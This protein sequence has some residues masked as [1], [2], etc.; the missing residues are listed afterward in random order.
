MNNNS[1]IKNI[2]DKISVLIIR[3]VNEKFHNELLKSYLDYLIECYSKYEF[4][5]NNIDLYLNAFIELE[6]S[7]WEDLSEEEKLILLL[8]D[9]S[10]EKIRELS[11]RGYDYAIN[12]ITNSESNGNLDINTANTYIKNLEELLPL[13][14]EHNAALAA[15]LVSE[16]ILDY[17]FASTDTNNTSLRIGRLR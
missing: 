12:K 4:E 8:K 7:K 13:V 15:N 14:R 1:L 10:L 11:G 2:Y 17:L 9:E 16:G 3:N 6:I 5:E